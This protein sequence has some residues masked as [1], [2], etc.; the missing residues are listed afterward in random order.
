MTLDG[1]T[2]AGFP[3]ASASL[4]SCCATCRASPECGAFSFVGF[5]NFPSGICNMR[6]DGWVRVPDPFER[7]DNLLPTYS[8]VL[9]STQPSTVVDFAARQ[10]DDLML[11]CG[12]GTIQQVTGA[13][14]G[15]FSVEDCWASGVT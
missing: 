2:A 5:K 3:F 7:P 12:S 4:E 1:G 9:S 8:V 10:G 13:D 15:T 14:Y 6:K 11:R